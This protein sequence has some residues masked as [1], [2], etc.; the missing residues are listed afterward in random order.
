VRVRG[1]R[2]PASSWPFKLG[3]IHRETPR[4]SRLLQVGCLDVGSAPKLQREPNCKICDEPANAVDHIIA[5][6]E[7]G[8]DLDPANLQSLCKRHHNTKTT[9]EGH[10]GMKR[11]ARQRRNPP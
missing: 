3:P 6:A 5:I 4:T 1:R 8:A 7:G 2:M 9:H 10:A 11:A